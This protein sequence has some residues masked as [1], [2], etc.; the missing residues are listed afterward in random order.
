MTTKQIT[1]AP[2]IAFR[3]L[4]G[5]LL[6]LAFVQTAPARDDWIFDIRSGVLYDSNVSHSDRATDRKDDVA[7]RTVLSAGQGFQLT[8]DLR[9]GIFGQVEGQLWGT[10]S[11]LNNI[12]PGVE[13]NLRYRFGLGKNAPWIRLETK[14][15]Y[16][17]FSDEGRSGWD[18]RPGLS[19]G[20]GLTDRFRVDATYGYDRFA[21]REAVWEHQGHSVSVHGR[22]E[23]TLSIQMVVGYGYRYGDV[24]SAAIPPRPDIVAIADV[25]ERTETFDKP[26]VAY[27]FP[28]STQIGAIAVS[29]ALSSFAA[30]QAS[31]E[32]QYT[33]HHPLH[34]INHVAELALAISF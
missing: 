6:C 11:G 22:I 32:F 33:T 17:D 18:F 15:S 29:Q 28:A 2:S 23:L 1:R 3:R 31:Y 30:I 26:Y 20:V 9:L 10:Y 16:A 7:W 5:P 8:D 19:G 12:R 34:Y 13:T 4:L 27:R 24:N 14:L 25:R 21:A